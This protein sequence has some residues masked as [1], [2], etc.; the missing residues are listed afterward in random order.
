MG[1]SGYS[2]RS[3]K[4]CA[5]DKVKQK[6]LLSSKKK[7]EVIETLANN[8]RTRKILANHR[9]VKTP[10]EQKEMNA[11]RALASDISEGLK[12]VTHSGSNEKRVALKAFTSL[13]FGENKK[14]TRAGK[15]LGKI[16]DFNAKSISKAIRTLESILK[17]DTESWL[18]TKRKVCQDAISEEDD[19]T[20]F[21]Y[22]TN[23]ASRPTG[24]KR[25][26][27]KKRI[28]KQQYVHHAKHVLEKTQ[29]EAFLEFQQLYPD[30][31]VKQ[32]KFESLKPFF[33]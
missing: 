21:N 9:V 3:S 1:E 5:T 18:Y 7:A 26:I 16:V 10:E 4:K 29:T 31:K 27:V 24:N 30:V 12:Q 25:D 23:T 15:S 28:G 17:G 13:A 2:N 8:P 19:Q 32:R 6:L 33:C 22:W 14:K 11:L 20:I